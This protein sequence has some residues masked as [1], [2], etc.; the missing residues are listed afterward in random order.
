MHKSLR[1][2]SP[3]AAVPHCQ[4]NE[5]G[6]GGYVRMEP[7]ASVIAAYDLARAGGRSRADAFTSAVNAYLAH[8]PDM[9]VSEA[10]GE[11]ARIL[12]HAAVGSPDAAVLCGGA[13][14]AAPRPSI[15]W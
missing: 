5:Q 13:A 2:R 7:F 4:P 1:E 15:S 6:F 9:R 3:A 12:L 11:V 10:G 8:R 14:E